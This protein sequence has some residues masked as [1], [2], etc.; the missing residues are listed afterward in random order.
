MTNFINFLNE[1]FGE[2]NY[3]FHGTSNMKYATDIIEDEVTK[4]FHVTDN[5]EV[6]MSYAG[7]KGV[8]VVVANKKEFGVQSKITLNTAAHIRGQ[9]QWVMDVAEANEMI[10]TADVAVAVNVWAIQKMVA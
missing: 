2:N 3:K 9:N 6:A 8:V 5:V 10:E 1:K 7:N 4:T